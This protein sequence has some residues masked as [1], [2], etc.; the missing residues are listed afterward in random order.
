MERN[1]PVSFWQMKFRLPPLNTL[2]LFEA[3]GRHLNF[4]TAAQ[5]LGIT[6]SAISHGIQALEDWLGSALFHRNGRIVTLTTA[7]EAY[8]PEVAEALSLLATAADHGASNTLHISAAPVFA[9]R[10]LLPRL[11]RFS[12]LHPHIAV[13]VD[14]RHGVV[15]FPRDG[16][17]L[18]IRRGHGDWAGL[19]AELLL[20]ESLVPVC[21]PLLLERLGDNRSL[22]SAPSST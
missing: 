12:E 1:D 16:A 18:A 20:T 8:L 5:E 22:D 13:S 3:A 17:D 21:S 9:S 7:G 4:K 19:S 14:T 11:P 2:R 10:I 15:E 6:P